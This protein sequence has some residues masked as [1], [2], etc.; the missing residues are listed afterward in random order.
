MYKLAI[1]HYCISA[2]TEY[3][4][5]WHEGH[6][7]LT[8]VKGSVTVRI[9]N[10]D[11]ILKPGE[12]ICI[13]PYQIH[14]FQPIE[15]AEYSCMLIMPDFYKMSGIDINTTIFKN[16][17]CDKILAELASK[18]TKELIDK[19]DLMYVAR[20]HQYAIEYFI[21][22][23]KNYRKEFS[24]NIQYQSKKHLAVINALNFINENYQLKISVDDISE[25]S[26]YS[27]YHFARIFKEYTGTNII[28]HI[29]SKRINK[30]K[31]LLTQNIESIDK[32]ALECGF[33]NSSYFAKVF[34][35]HCGCLPTEFRKNN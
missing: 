7:F 15:Y 26:G 18:I 11:I 30:A 4:A 13:N 12:S 29:N 1:P 32:I 35:D 27:R 9:D 22:M 24:N 28:N 5:H 34:R 20:I 31:K 10:E 6:E 23:F 2:G 8:G 19:P 33:E 21:H 17:Y 3:P 25:A 14:S 16:S